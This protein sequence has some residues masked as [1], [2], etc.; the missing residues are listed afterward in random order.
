[1]RAIR[2]YDQPSGGLA[3]PSAAD[4]Q[5][6]RDSFP[7]DQNGSY[8][9]FPDPR[10]VT[11]GLAAPVR[12]LNRRR[13]S[14]TLVTDAGAATW[15]QR[16]NGRWASDPARHRNCLDV[17]RSLLAS[18]FGRPTVAAPSSPPGR[19]AASASSWTARRARRA[20]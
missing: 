8:Q 18:W 20:G 12:E 9:R 6:L 5:R 4:E 1:M 13:P 19:A 11:F 2:P 14:N 7:V 3:R 16:V 15:V 17:S 10:G